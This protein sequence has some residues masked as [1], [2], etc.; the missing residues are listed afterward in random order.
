[1]VLKCQ[2]SERDGTKN[3]TFEYILMHL[4]TRE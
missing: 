1:M 2:N 4:L 3:K